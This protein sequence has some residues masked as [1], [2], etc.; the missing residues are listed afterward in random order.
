MPL[1]AARFGCQRLEQE[2]ALERFARRDQ[3]RDSFKVAVGLLFRPRLAPCRERLEL[4]R[5]GE[6]CMAGEAGYPATRGASALAWIREDRLDT[7]AIEI[8]VQRG[9]RPAGLRRRR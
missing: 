5:R 1:R 4:Q 9:R 7:A 3:F 8:E 6:D 2:P